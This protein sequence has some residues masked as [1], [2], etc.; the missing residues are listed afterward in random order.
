MSFF[1]RY[2]T[3]N[4][5]RTLDFSLRNGQ[6]LFSQPSR[7]ICSAADEVT[8]HYINK[9]N[10]RIT[11]KGKVGEDIMRLAQKHGIEIEGACEASVACSTCHIYVQN[12]YYDK[13]KEP[14]ENEE[15]MLDMAP[16]LKS[17]S[18]L[19]CQIVLTKELDGIE[20]KL[21]PATRNFYVD[22]KVPQPH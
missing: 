10:E 13:L 6:V 18:R 2:L 3:A 4:S 22:G 19:G 15:D 5:F 20:V 12:D 14:E 8:V 7:T 16:F 21:P 11:V 9:K 17:N 1:R